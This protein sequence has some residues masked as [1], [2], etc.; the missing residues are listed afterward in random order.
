MSRIQNTHEKAPV[1]FN[2][3]FLYPIRRSGR[4]VAIITSQQVGTVCDI[5]ENASKF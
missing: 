1:H 2:S 5:R 3:I 4:G